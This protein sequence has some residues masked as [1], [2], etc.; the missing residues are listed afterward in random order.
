LYL[1]DPQSLAIL[2]IDKK[3]RFVEAHNLKSPLRRFTDGDRKKRKELK[4]I[5]IGGF[6]VDEHGNMF[7]SIPS[8]F[9]VFRVSPEGELAAFG[10]SGSSPGKFGVVSGVAVD[11]MGNIYVTDRLRCVVSIFNSDFVFLKEF[12]H[13]GHR[14]SN[15]VV[16]TDIAISREGRVYV[17]QAANRGVSV[18]KVVYKGLPSIEENQLGD[19]SLELTQAE[20]EHLT[21]NNELENLS[22]EELKLS[23]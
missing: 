18:F 1:I 13:R 8:M 22:N 14:P 6:D 7:F 11:D 16:P 17:S 2:I 5:D 19:N 15:L 21:I 4:D 12:G 10:K 3:G 9:T 20:V 23:N